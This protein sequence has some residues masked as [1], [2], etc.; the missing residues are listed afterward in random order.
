MEAIA[1]RPLTFPAV[2]QRVPENHP[3]SRHSLTLGGSFPD[4][5]EN[6]GSR[7]LCLGIRAEICHSSGPDFSPP[8]S[9]QA[10]IPLIP[11]SKTNIL[12]NLQDCLCS[13]NQTLT[14]TP[15]CTSRTQENLLPH[16]KQDCSSFRV[17]RPCW[18]PNCTQPQCAAPQHMDLS[19]K[20]PVCSL[21]C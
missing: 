13:P 12:W 18:V 21:S 8:A 11:F 6:Y 1:A 10:Y 2:S 17:G 20:D 7:E 15:L 5:L 16:N 14:Y 19:S 4:I 3:L 9:Q